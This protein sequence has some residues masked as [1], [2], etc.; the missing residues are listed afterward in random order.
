M[1]I[2]S[3][4][5]EDRAK[6]LMVLTALGRPVLS[7]TLADHPTLADMSA[8]KIGS[9]LRFMV[10]GKEVRRTRDGSWVAKNAPVKAA[11]DENVSMNDAFFI[12][13]TQARTIKLDVGGMRLPVRIE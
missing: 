5:R 3:Q 11:P 2:A 13:D 9:Y 7:A 10:R 1:T 12:I 6:I 4:K 8:Q